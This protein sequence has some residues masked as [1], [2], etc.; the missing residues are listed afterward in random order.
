MDNLYST[1]LRPIVN[2]YFEEKEKEV[3]DYKEF[4]S[5][6]GAGYCMRKNIFDRLKVPHTTSDPRKQRIFQAGHLFHEFYQRR[7]MAAGISVAQEAELMDD[8]LM[9]KGHIDDL[10]VIDGHPI[11]YDYKSQNSMAFHWAKK[12][13]KG[14]SHYHKLQLGTYLYLLRKRP[15]LITNA[16]GVVEQVDDYIGKVDESRILKVSKDDMSESEEQLL[17]NAGLEKTIY[18]YWST[19]NGYWKAKT[20][21]KCTCA[22]IEPNQ[23]TGI[24]FMASDKYNPYFFQGEPCSL[25]WYK[26]FKEG[27]CDD[28]IKKAN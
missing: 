5:A 13:G 7:S 18:E 14:I 3:R 20:L 19:L 26:I 8:K 12:S 6:S 27:K 11:L 17:W 10:I 9:V 2:A 23:K 15:M 1:G 21:P 25:S 4:W 28:Y 24:G 22:E 16:D